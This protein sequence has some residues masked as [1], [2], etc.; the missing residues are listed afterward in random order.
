[1]THLPFFQFS[2]NGANGGAPL[3]TLKG[4]LSAIT[5]LGYSYQGDRIL[6]ASQKDG[7]VRIWSWT[8]DPSQSSRKPSQILIQLS[9]PKSLE[10]E[11]L[12]QSSRRRPSRATSSRISCD[13]AVWASD[14]NTVITSQSES[15]KQN[16]SEIIPG[17]QY[18]FLWDSHTGDCLLGIAGAHSMQ[19]SVIIPHPIDATIL[20]SAGADGLAKLWNLPSGKCVSSFKN[21]LEFGPIDIRDKGKACGFL[22]GAFS[23]DGTNLVLTDD[24]GRVSFFDCSS[25]DVDSDGTIVG[26]NVSWMNEQYFSNDYYDLHYDVNGYC[27]ERNSELP[28]HL[29]PRGVRC[30]NSGAPWPERVTDAFCGLVG[31]SPIDEDTARWDRQN[32]AFMSTHAVSRRLTAKGNLIGQF[33][34]QTTVLTSD[35]GVVPK[36]VA[37]GIVDGTAVT[38]APERAPGGSSSH[39]MSNNY[40]WRDYSDMIL[41]EG[42]G[43]D[44]VAL[45]SDEDFEINEGRGRQLQENSESDEEL[46]DVYEDS[47]ARPSGGERAARASARRRRITDADGESEGEMPARVSSRRR[48]RSYIDSESES[49]GVEYMST[50]NAPSGPFLEDYDAHFFRLTDSRSH[51]VERLW[52]RRLESNSSYGGRKSYTPQVGDSVVYIPRAHHD[53]ISQFPSLSAPWHNWPD[54]AL[55]PVVRC[56]IRNIR[57]RF[58]FK[59]YFGRNTSG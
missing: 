32:I 57:Y 5:D 13:V 46:E 7:V 52:V 56:C 9:N 30:S 39:R 15:E 16:G 48:R 17:S 11:A 24:S 29:A 34:P 41:E 45:D 22:D 23:P 3:L 18:I 10:K 51:S 14:D 53:T 19:C 50:N 44:E 20:C 40:R 25:N 36:M 35:S 43:E 12:L 8:V 1:L 38:A 59:D 37:Q 26:N 4:H 54:E 49:E 58:P 33:D 31:P 42:N 47:P 2:V 27:V 28:P 6:S 55:W 21:T